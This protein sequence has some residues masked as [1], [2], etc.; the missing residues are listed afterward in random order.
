MVKFDEASL[1]KNTGSDMLVI[2]PYDN[3]FITFLISLLQK[4]WERTP[5]TNT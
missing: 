4:F 5:L 2:I 3:Y 1:H